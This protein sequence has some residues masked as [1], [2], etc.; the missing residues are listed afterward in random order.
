MSLGRNKSAD[1]SIP[2]YSVSAEHALLTW[3]QG[4]RLSIED[5]GASNGIWIEAAGMKRLG[6]GEVHVFEGSERVILGR[7]VFDFLYFEALIN[8]LSCSAPENAGSQR[9]VKKPSGGFFQRLFQGW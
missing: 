2:E 5:I 3:K 7:I 6:R 1:I 9:R 8:M 4:K